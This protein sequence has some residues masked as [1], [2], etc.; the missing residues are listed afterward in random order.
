MLILL[1]NSNTKRAQFIAGI[2]GN[3]GDSNTQQQIRG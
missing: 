2:V 1:V 3:R